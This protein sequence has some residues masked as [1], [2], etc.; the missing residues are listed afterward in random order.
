MAISVNE[1]VGSLQEMLLYS[2]VDGEGS[3]PTCKRLAKFISENQDSLFQGI[4]SLQEG[5]KEFL[6]KNIEKI[7]VGEDVVENFVN[8]F[9]GNDKWKSI[10]PKVI[11]YLNEIKDGSLHVAPHGISEL[12]G[13]WSIR[14]ITRKED[15]SFELDIRRPATHFLVSP[16]SVDVNDRSAIDI[17]R[18]RLARARFNERYGDRKVSVTEEN[19][20]EW[21]SQIDRYELV[22]GLSYIK[23]DLCSCHQALEDFQKAK[24]RHDTVRKQLND[25]QTNHQNLLSEDS[26]LKARVGR[27]T[28]WFQRH[29]SA[30][31]D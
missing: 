20:L 6:L 31:N 8:L 29:E 22:E 10:L 25:I 16:A 26:E 14:G 28:D 9:C 2:P 18:D 5:R 23:Q 13:S 17:D 12:H 19:I 30:F 24:Q 7:G 21:H 15:G 4:N 27:Y 1:A 11:N 3:E